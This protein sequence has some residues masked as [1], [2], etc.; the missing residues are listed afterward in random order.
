MI[1]N[2]KFGVHACFSYSVFFYNFFSF[3]FFFLIVRRVFF[4]FFFFF[5]SP[6]YLFLFYAFYLTRNRAVWSTACRP[7]RKGRRALRSRA[8]PRSSPRFARR[9]RR[10]SRSSGARAASTRR[11]AC[12]ASISPPARRRARPWTASWRAR[13]WPRRLPPMRWGPVAATSFAASIK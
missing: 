1:W 9:S 12:A 11:C 6:P 2:Q 5:F 10:C 3:L 7:S 13:A 4:F 8:F